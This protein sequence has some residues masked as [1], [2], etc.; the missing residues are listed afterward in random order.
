M[1]PSGY[2]PTQADSLC[3]FL[4]SCV[5]ALIEENRGLRDPHEAI[6]RE[7]DSITR[8]L[9]DEKRP[10]FEQDLLSFTRAFYQTLIEKCPASL[11]ELANHAET[12]LADVHSR[13]LSIH[14]TV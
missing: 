13:I 4:R 1:P 3:E 14:V 10:K 8:D 6:R 7:M 11:E 2:N 9:V 12:C 5:H